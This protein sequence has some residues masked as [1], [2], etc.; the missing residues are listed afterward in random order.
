MSASAKSCPKCGGRMETGFIL[1]GTRHNPHGVTKWIQG[2]PEFGL[3]KAVKVRGKTKLDIET[4]RCGRCAYLE[5]YA[6]TA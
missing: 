1:E 5:S 2:A 6:P 4:W 3:F